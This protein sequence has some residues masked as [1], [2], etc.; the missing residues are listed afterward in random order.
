MKRG[1]VAPSKEYLQSKE[2]VIA[3]GGAYNLRERYRER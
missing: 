3:F 1:P 2:R